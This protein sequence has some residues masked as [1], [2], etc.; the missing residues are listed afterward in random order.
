ME[1]C[2][3]SCPYGG[4]VNRQVNNRAFF[5]TEEEHM[6]TFDGFCD[7]CECVITLE[8]DCIELVPH[9]K[10]KNFDFN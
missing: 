10:S 2:S 5:K 8:L 1:C 4:V 9:S 6:A 3:S 7:K